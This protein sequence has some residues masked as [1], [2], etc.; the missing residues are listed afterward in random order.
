MVCIM[1]SDVQRADVDVQLSVRLGNDSLDMRIACMHACMTCGIDWVP[2]RSPLNGSTGGGIEGR[3][4]LQALLQPQLASQALDSRLS[5][6]FFFFSFIQVFLVFFAE[7]VYF[8]KICILLRIHINEFCVV[9][10]FKAAAQLRS[11]RLHSV[12]MLAYTLCI[13]PLFGNRGLAYLRT[14]LI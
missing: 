14:A 10:L 9:N 2:S 6:F 7:I 4:L 13:F 1:P 12:Y 11:W 3:R 5:V 8:E